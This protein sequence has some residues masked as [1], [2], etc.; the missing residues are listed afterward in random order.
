M[1]LVELKAVASVLIFSENVRIK[2]ITLH[3]TKK[4]KTNFLAHI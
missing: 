3:F 4:K 1:G 2:N